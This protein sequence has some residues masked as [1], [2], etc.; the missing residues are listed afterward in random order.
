MK[1]MQFF[2]VLLLT[3]MVSVFFTSCRPDSLDDPTQLIKGKWEVTRMDYEAEESGCQFF[4]KEEWVWEFDGEELTMYENDRYNEAYRYEVEE[5][6]LYTEYA[7][8]YMAKY[9]KITTLNDTKLV[10]DVS[11]QYQG[12]KAK[13]SFVFKRM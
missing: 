4:D 1:K 3:A 8:Y 12:E 5:N 2:M 13:Y 10:L 11:Y 9:F 7:T 6:K